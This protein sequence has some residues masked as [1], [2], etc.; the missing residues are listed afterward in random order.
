MIIDAHAHVADLSLFPTH[1]LNGMMEVLRQ[2]A[3]DEQG[4]TLQTTL[5]ER[6]AKHQLSDPECTKLLSEMKIARIDKTVLL[7][8]DFGF[9]E[10]DSG[11]SLKSLYHQYSKV[12]QANPDKFVV[13][14]GTDPRRGQWAVDLFEHGI[15]QLGFRG[16]K[17][18]PPCGYD[19]DDPS[20][21]P[22][23]ELCRAHGI[24]VLAHTGPSL[25]SMQ[26]DQRYPLSILRAADRF[27]S[28]KF[29]LGHAAFQSF[30][31]NPSIAVQ[32]RNVYLETSGFQRLLDSVEAIRNHLR[33]LF[34]TIPHQVVF[35]TDWPVFNIRAT[36]RDWV[37]FFENLN[38]L[39]RAEKERFFYLNA[40]E[41]LGH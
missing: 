9:G 11:S 36:Q 41:A 1:F 38:V 39:S 33:T 15:T 8:A 2:R 6:I 5:L 40:Q 30:E 28:V 37:L 31:T 18:Y 20:L 25:R 12:L 27:P 23:Y 4:V 32:R 22:Y 34:D 16:L 21:D 19:L 26:G 3:L 13:F 29:I 7:I 17:L 24:P 14:G 10:E 35:G